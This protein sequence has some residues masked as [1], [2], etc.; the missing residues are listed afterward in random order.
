MSFFPR[1]AFYFSLFAL[2][3][4]TLGVD[5]AAVV[6]VRRDVCENMPNSRLARRADT[7]VGGDVGV[8]VGLPQLGLSLG[9][10]TTKLGNINLTVTNVTIATGDIELENIHI[11]NITIIVSVPLPG[12]SP[13]SAF[14]AISSSTSISTST[15]TGSSSVF[16]GTTVT[17]SGTTVTETVSSN[18]KRHA[19]RQDTSDSSTPGTPTTDP[20]GSGTTVSGGASATV[21]GSPIT[22]DTGNVYTEIGNISIFVGHVNV[23]VGDVK[24]KNVTLGNIFVLVQIGQ[25]D[26]N[27]LVGNITNSI[28]NALPGA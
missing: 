1:L 10:I 16:K 25:P 27:G 9:N 12:A 18:L 5:P 3:W 22:L 6:D 8:S 20:T 28:G 11:G 23:S 17:Q 26:L 14:S 15:G 21:T 19:R 24:I 2:L 7:D 4:P 13:V